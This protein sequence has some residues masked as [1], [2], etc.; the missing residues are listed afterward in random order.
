MFSRITTIKLLSNVLSGSLNE[1]YVL[2][3]PVTQPSSY[4]FKPI[5][6]FYF[7]SGDGYYYASYLGSSGSTTYGKFYTTC[8]C[9][10]PTPTPTITPTPIPTPTPTIGPCDETITVSK[11]T[12]TV[13][14]LSL[15][16]VQY[17]DFNNYQAFEIPNKRGTRVQDYYVLTET[18]IIGGN[19]YNPGVIFIMTGTGSNVK[20]YPADSWEIDHYCKNA[21]SRKIWLN[22]FSTG[23]I[24]LAS[25]ETINGDWVSTS[26]YAT[27]LKIKRYPTNQID[28]INGA[29]VLVR[30]IGGTGFNYQPITLVYQLI[31]NKYYTSFSPSVPYN[32]GYVYTSCSTCSAPAPVNTEGRDNTT[33]IGVGLL[34]LMAVA[35]LYSTTKRNN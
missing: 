29:S 34:A 23:S 13:L 31:D 19:T 16:V 21:P 30:R 22:T 7:V 26:V 3:P 12:L 24:T 8:T 17:T 1:F 2:I 33:I 20:I 28:V 15:P 6:L 11:A 32:K 25:G 35:L 10:L 18:R 27:T 14:G 5:T 9:P 4:G